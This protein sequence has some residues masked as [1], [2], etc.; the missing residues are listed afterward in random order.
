MKTCPLIAAIAA[1]TFCTCGAV[2]LP[3]A[4]SA[5]LAGPFTFD[6][7]PG[8]EGFRNRLLPADL[9]ITRQDFGYRTTNQAHGDEPGEIGGIVERST[10][11]ATY[12]KRIAPRSLNDR[13]SA[14]GKLVVPH[15][16]GASGVM[17]GWFNETSRGW[18]TPNSLGFRIDGN[19][20]KYWMFYEYG[21]RNWHTGGGGAFEGDRYQTTPTPPFPSGARYTPGRSTTIRTAP[22]GWAC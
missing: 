7:D 8:W 20:G 5:E 6:K 13:L 3:H 19:G 4:R 9:P 10:V 18:R 22:T 17:V 2:D 15:A 14:S 11:P 16:E 12:G 21:T 1:T